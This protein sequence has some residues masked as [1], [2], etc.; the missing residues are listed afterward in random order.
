MSASTNL[1]TS[2]EERLR[3]CDE[4]RELIDDAMR[5]SFGKS[6]TMRLGDSVIL[7]LLSRLMR[8]YNGLLT[9]ARANYSEQAMMLIR[10]LFETLVDIGWTAIDRERAVN[11]LKEHHQAV[12]TLE[13]ATGE[14]ID[15]Q[16][17]LAFKAFVEDAKFPAWQARDAAEG[18]QRAYKH[19]SGK[20]F[21]GR[22]REV[23]SAGI[24]KARIFVESLEWGYTNIATEAEFVLHGAG[25]T[26]DKVARRAELGG[27]VAGV[28]GSGPSAAYSDD[29]LICGFWTTARV[30][31]LAF[32]ELD[33][34]ARAALDLLY[35]R[36]MH[37][38]MP[39]PRTW[40][41][42]KQGDDL[43]PCG[44]R[45]SLAECHVWSGAT[46]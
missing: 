16:T 35:E 31:W 27:V 45:R 18:E 19:W 17:E 14:H 15:A 30:A 13:R 37:L 21:F 11:S 40:A 34:P 25:I 8:T 26:M 6:P 9:L 3:V 32:R 12:L 44:L 46:G 4:L 2:Y 39:I 5:E 24:Y 10:P 28:T 20:S 33:V 22:Y 38:L 23:T 36:G 41:E 7:G 29:V 1:W 42:G 43:C